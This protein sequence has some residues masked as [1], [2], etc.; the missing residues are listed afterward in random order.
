MKIV[1][2]P[3]VDVIETPIGNMVVKATKQAIHHIYFDDEQVD[4]KLNPSDLTQETKNQLQQYFSGSLRYFDL[5]IEQEGTPFQ[6]QVWSA[7]QQIP[8]GKRISYLNLAHQF[9]DENLVRAVANANGK[10]QLAIVVPCHRVVGSDGK[11]TG[12]AWGLKR[13]SWLLDFEAKTSGQKL[14]LF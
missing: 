2:F 6:H 10:N 3:F 9:N 5:P 13:K 11:L 1:A 12:Y 4:L 14:S 7:L 8:Y